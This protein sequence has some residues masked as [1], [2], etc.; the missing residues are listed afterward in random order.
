[1]CEVDFSAHQAKR[2][3]IAQFSVH[4]INLYEPGLEPGI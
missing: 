3:E 1:M 2:A 4:P